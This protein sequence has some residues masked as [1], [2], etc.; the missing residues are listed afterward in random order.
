V[1]PDP[2]ESVE[3]TS[4]ETVY[5]RDVSRSIIARN[6]SPDIGFDASINPYRGCS[7]GCAYCFARSTHEYLGLSVGLD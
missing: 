4:P 5:L 7:H 6:D 3:Q 2:S 1:E